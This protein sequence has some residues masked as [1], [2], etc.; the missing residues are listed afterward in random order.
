MRTCHAG[1]VRRSAPQ[2]PATLGSPGW[3]TDFLADR[4]VRKPSAH[5]IKAYRQDFEA[6]ATLLTGTPD[7]VPDLRTNELTKDTLRTAFGAYANTHSAASI[8]RCLSTWNTLCTFLFTAELLEANPM[9]VIGRSKVPKSLTKSYPAQAVT[10]L[11]AAIDSDD[12]SARRSDW[13]ERDRAIV[14]TPRIA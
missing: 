8:R 13:P 9:P 11:V 12:K 3:F 5:T 1:A 14:F 2:Q 7:A 4:A 10:D 6:I